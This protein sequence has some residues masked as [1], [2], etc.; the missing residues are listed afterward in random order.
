MANT[1]RVS[2]KDQP[3]KGSPFMK[4][5]AR[6]LMCLAAVVAVTACGKKENQGNAGETIA[7]VPQPSQRCLDT[8]SQSAWTPYSNYGFMPY[9]GYGSQGYGGTGVYVGG[10][11]GFHGQYGYQNGPATT[12]MSSPW[13]AWTPQRGFCGCPSGTVP[14]CDNSAGMACVNAHHLNNVQYRAWGF[15]P[16]GTS[17]N[18]I[19]W[20]SL[21]TQNSCYQGMAQACQVGSLQCGYGAVCM[22]TTQNSPIG[23]C[24]RH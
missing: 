21:P 12:P 17:W 13:P 16:I 19:G 14:T 9:Q 6:L 10:G 18:Q 11:F 5:I 15:D 24:V 2:P 22:P 20:G 1:G 3:I 8:F 7:T 23:V 4:S